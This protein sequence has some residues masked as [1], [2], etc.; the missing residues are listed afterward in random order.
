AGRWPRPIPLS[1]RAPLI[2]SPAKSIRVIRPAKSLQ[3]RTCRLLRHCNPFRQTLSGLAQSG[4]HDARRTRYRARHASAQPTIPPGVSVQ[5]LGAAIYCAAGAAGLA[6]VSG[7]D[8]AARASFSQFAVK[9]L[10]KRFFSAIFSLGVV[11][12]SSTNSINEETRSSGIAVLLLTASLASSCVLPFI[13][14]S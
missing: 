9:S 14:I 7:A 12:S 13:R 1:Q 3:K 11:H 10:I 2:W 4:G 8:D 6:G 5:A